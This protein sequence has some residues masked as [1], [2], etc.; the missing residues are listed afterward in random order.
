MTLDVREHSQHNAPESAVKILPLG[1]LDLETG[2]HLPQT[3]IAYEVFGE[4]NA[5]RSNAVLVLHA[6]T[7]DT[8]AADGAPAND[9]PA[10]DASVTDADAP[11]PGWWRE[12]V[13][14]GKPVDTTMY[15]AVVPAA[16]GGCSGTIGPASLAEDGQPYGSRFP[17]VTIRDMVELELRLMHALN[18]EAW[19]AV[20]G[21][22]MGGARALEWAVSYPQHVTK[23]AVIAAT[24]ESSAEQIAFAQIQTEAIRLDPQFHGGDYYIHGNGAGPQRGLGIARRLAH[25]SYRSAA[26]LDHRFGRSPQGSE[27]PLGSAGRD[28]RGRYAVESYLDH[29]A[30]KLVNRFDAN[31]YLTLTEALMSHDVGRGRGGVEAALAGV[32]GVEF[33]IAAVDTDRLYYP[34]ESQR[35]ADALPGDVPVHMVSTPVG[36]DGFLTDG[37][38]LDAPF[39]AFLGPVPPSA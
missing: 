11:Q 7:G 29:Q 38:Q 35:I 26:E 25:V 28:E 24:A 13:G 3:H 33:F 22:S 20:V 12:V 17:F 32:E 21:G 10:N 39:R 5:E 19:H 36:H 15:C 8:H 30:H 27:L 2:G 6:L 31:A 9:V 1:P 16:L 14:P 34:Q 23:C 18:I 37:H 4:L